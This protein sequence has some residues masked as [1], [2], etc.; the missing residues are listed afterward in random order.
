MSSRSM[1]QQAISICPERPEG[2]FL[3]SR[4]FERDGSRTRHQNQS[5]EFW[6]SSYN[7]ACIGLNMADHDLPALRSWVDYPGKYGL[8]FE[9]AVAGWWC[10]FGDQ[11]RD[12]FRTL[13]KN[14]DVLPN[15]RKACEYNLEK[16]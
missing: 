4:R 11:S 3:L 9:K 15:Y 10:G 7:Y 1:Y 6:F 14:K 8:E 12:L 2:Y 16:L 13:L 5:V